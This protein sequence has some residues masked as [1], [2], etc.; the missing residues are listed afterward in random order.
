M[1]Y[2]APIGAIDVSNSNTPGAVDPT[3]PVGEGFYRVVAQIDQHGKIRY[4]LTNA[5]SGNN[6]RAAILNGS[7]NLIY[8]SGNAGNGSNPQPDG[9][10]IGAGTQ[11]MNSE[12]KAEVAQKPG[13]PTPVGSFNVTQLGDAA[14]KT[15]KD[16]NFR[17]LTIHNNIL[18]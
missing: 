7:A 10:I 5:Y 1:G 12:V 4:T 2:L 3:N 17:G 8:T 14:D 15:G 9:I 11:I 16:T 6:G 13:A 18:Y